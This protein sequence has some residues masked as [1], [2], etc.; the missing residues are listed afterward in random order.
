MNI[1][2]F[3]VWVR[4]KFRAFGITFGTLEKGAHVLYD[5]SFSFNLIDKEPAGLVTVFD[6]RGVRLAVAS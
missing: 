6:Q 1:F 5:G 3:K 2:T 4:V